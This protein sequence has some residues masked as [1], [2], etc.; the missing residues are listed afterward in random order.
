MTASLSDEAAGL[1]LGMS[2]VAELVLLLVA[3]VTIGIQVPWAMLLSEARNE[4]C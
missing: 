4:A 3:I 1:V 2:A